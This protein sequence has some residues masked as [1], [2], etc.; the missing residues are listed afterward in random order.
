MAEEQYINYEERLLQDTIRFENGNFMWG[1][2]SEIIPENEID[3]IL[4]ALSRQREMQKV[5]GSLSNLDIKTT[6]EYQ[7]S[8]KNI[9]LNPIV[10]IENMTEADLISYNRTGDLLYGIDTTYINIG[11]QN[12]EGDD[13]RASGEYLDSLYAELRQKELE[14]EMGRTYNKGMVTGAG[15][16]LESIVPRIKTPWIDSKGDRAVTTIGGERDKQDY[17]RDF[18]DFTNFLGLGP[19]VGKDIGTGIHRIASF[20]DYYLGF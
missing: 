7:D 9:V 13:G 8:L 20:L 19:D 4:G 10:D 16:L 6:K 15:T 17:R 2:N 1:S 11:E 12:L 18:G 5:V 14:G 3:D